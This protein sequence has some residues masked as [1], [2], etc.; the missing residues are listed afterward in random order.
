MLTNAMPLIHGHS[1]TE[2]ESTFEWN[3]QH[4][5]DRNMLGTDLLTI[6]MDDVAKPSQT[7]V[8]ISTTRTTN[9]ILH[10]CNLVA[11][12]YSNVLYASVETK[13]LQRPMGK[14]YKG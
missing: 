12:D 7:R 5:C 11:P 10:P 8:L 2:S 6:I 9:G 13:V 14:W 1:S 3:R 4:G